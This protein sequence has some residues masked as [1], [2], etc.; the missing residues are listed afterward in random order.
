MDEHRVLP[1]GY[2]E[3][4][5][6]YGFDIGPY[7]NFNRDRTRWETYPATPRYGVQYFASRTNRHP[8]RIVHLRVV[9]SRIA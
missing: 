3:S 2:Q 7:G 4:E 5:G 6:G 8:V 1:V 9:G